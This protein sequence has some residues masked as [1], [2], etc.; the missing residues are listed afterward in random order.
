MDFPLS[1]HFPLSRK[2]GFFKK[3][4]LGKWVFLIKRDK[5]R[6]CQRF[7]QS[8]GFGVRTRRTGN[9]SIHL[10]EKGLAT[11]AN[12]FKKRVYGKEAASV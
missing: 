2:R 4:I 7:S 9:F 12:S 8:A 6:V 3:S 10:Q 1:A 5:N 11:Y